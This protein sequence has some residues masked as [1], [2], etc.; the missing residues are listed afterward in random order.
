MKLIQY[1]LIKSNNKP[2]NTR[3]HIP[4]MGHFKGKDIYVRVFKAVKMQKVNTNMK[5]VDTLNFS[6]SKGCTITIESP[7]SALFLDV[8]VQTN[9]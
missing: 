9:A 7:K 4:Y 8:E 2:H 1:V 5:K 3:P 6:T